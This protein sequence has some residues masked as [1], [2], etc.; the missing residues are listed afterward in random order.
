LNTLDRDLDAVDCRSVQ[1]D[2]SNEREID[3][4]SCWPGALRGSLPSELNQFLAGDVFYI[5][6]PD[7]RLER[8]KDHR[9]RATNRL[10]N[11]GKV[12]EMQRNQIGKDA[13]LLVRF[14][15]SD[16]GPPIN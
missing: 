4:E 12:V 3:R 14:G 16:W 11:L 7:G 1:Q 6:A 10:A 2:G 13:R 5:H 8:F 15:A 9:F